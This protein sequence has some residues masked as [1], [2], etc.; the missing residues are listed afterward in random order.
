MR[1]AIK[2]RLRVW[3]VKAGHHLPTC[4]VPAGWHK[5]YA[6]YSGI[7][8]TYPAEVPVDGGEMGYPGAGGQYV[9]KSIHEAAFNATGALLEYY[10]AYDVRWFAA[11]NFFD[12]IADV[13]TSKLLPCNRTGQ[14]VDNTS[15]FTYLKTTGDFQGVEIINSG[16]ITSSLASNVPQ[17]WVETGLRSPFPT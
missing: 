3:K 14:L 9:P 17:I 13:N 10:K 6:A 5:N 11:G 8:Q 1:S 7:A 12:R 4:V 15:I 2:P 16:Q